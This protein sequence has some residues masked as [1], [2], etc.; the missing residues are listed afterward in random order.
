VPEQKYAFGIVKAAQA[1]GDFQ[2]LAERN[3]RALRVHPGRISQPA[4]LGFSGPS[5]RRWL[6]L[7]FT[8]R[9][10]E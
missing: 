4:S 3:R 10:S 5:S 9:P 8:H 2:V 6:S 1:R 7:V